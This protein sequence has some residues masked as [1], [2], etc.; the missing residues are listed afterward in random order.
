VEHRA[1]P[2]IPITPVLDI[3]ALRFR[4]IPLAVQSTAWEPLAEEGS[5]IQTTNTIL[6][7]CNPVNE[8]LRRSMAGHAMKTLRTPRL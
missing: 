1:L 7:S 6:H 8:D 3:Y 2:V 5:R 4:R